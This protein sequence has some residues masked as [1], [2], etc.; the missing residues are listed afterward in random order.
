VSTATDNTVIYDASPKQYAFLASLFTQ[1]V[2][3]DLNPELIE[4]CIREQ[5]LTK[6]GASNLIDMLMQ[7][8]RKPAAP[9]VH[10]DGEALTVGYYLQ[11]DTVYAIVKAKTSDNLYAKRLVSTERGSASWEY[12]RGAMN[13]LVAAHRLTLDD[14]KAMGT[15]LGVCVICAA[16]LTDPESVERGIGPVCAKRV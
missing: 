14:A 6:R 8:P 10:E 3:A 16:T 2:T 11:E 15:R 7:S 9:K 4:S 12:A 5:T 1:R 13:H